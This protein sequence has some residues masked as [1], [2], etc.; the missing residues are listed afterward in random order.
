MAALRSKPPE[1]QWGRALELG[2]E[3]TFAVVV[4]VGLGYSLD[5]WLGTEPIFLLVFMGFGFAAGV[6]ALL[7][8]SRAAAQPKNRGEASE[9]DDAGRE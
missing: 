9:P 4:G 2:I 3:F 7:R 6:R 1:T 5:R 8:F